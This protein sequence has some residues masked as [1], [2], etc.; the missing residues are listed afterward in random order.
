MWS[1]FLVWL[2]SLLGRFWSLRLDVT[3][4]LRVGTASV[5][6]TTEETMSK[7]LPPRDP[8]TGKFRKR[9]RRR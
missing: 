3:L 5:P 2:R 7:K 1:R 4:R 9:K 6:E 8:K